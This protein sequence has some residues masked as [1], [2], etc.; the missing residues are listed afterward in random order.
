M[1]DHT[2]TMLF[3]YLLVCNT[4]TTVTTTKRPDLTVYVGIASNPILRVFS[5]NRQEGYPAGARVTRSRAPKWDLQAVFGPFQSGG[6]HRFREWIITRLKERG[7]TGITIL[8]GQSAAATTA[9]DSTKRQSA[10]PSHHCPL[11]HEIKLWIRGSRELREFITS[12]LGI[13]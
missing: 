11:N 13:I 9:Q 5:H 1:N 6:T 10:L 2:R 12:S 7:P 8:K 3:V 4:T